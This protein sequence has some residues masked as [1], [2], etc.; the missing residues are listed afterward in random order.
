[1]TKHQ[2]A[3]IADELSEKA[4]TWPINAT[5]TVDLSKHK[6]NEIQ[7]NYSSRQYCAGGWKNI[8]KGII[9][10]VKQRIERVT[11]MTRRII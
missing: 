2:V 5:K 8:K 11:N 7:V 6:Q 1:M 3:E 10:H 4:E 9:L